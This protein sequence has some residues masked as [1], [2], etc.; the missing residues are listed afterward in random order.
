MQEVE[1]RYRRLLENDL[2]NVIMMRPILELWATLS[3]R[4]NLDNGSVLAQVTEALNPAPSVGNKPL[5]LN[6]AQEVFDGKHRKLAVYQ[7]IFREV[8]KDKRESSDSVRLQERYLEDGSGMV[9]GFGGRVSEDLILTIK[10]LLTETDT[11][12]VL[13][14]RSEDPA[15]VILSFLRRED[16]L[17]ESTREVLEVIESRQPIIYGEHSNFLE[18]FGNPWKLLDWLSRGYKKQI[19]SPTETD[20]TVPK[21]ESAAAVFN[22]FLSREGVS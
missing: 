8:E 7:G 6:T 14:V 1:S 22:K 16:V 18:T 17:W 10:T 15:T 3:E 11:E 21:V 20:G 12:M 13:P 5:Y 9:S 19:I 2:R 4:P